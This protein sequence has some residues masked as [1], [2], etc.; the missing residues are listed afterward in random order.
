MSKDVK[1]DD[2]RIFN[3]PIRFR[4]AELEVIRATGSTMVTWIQAA[5]RTALDIERQRQSAEK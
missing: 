2:R 1:I 4:Q 3:V 5:V